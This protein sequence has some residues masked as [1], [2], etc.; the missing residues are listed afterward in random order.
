MAGKPC[1]CSFNLSHLSKE[2]GA[3]HVK[4]SASSYSRWSL[5]RVSLH[6][7]GREGVGRSIGGDHDR[8]HLAWAILCWN[9]AEQPSRRSTSARTC[10]KP[11]DAPLASVGLHAPESHKPSLSNLVKLLLRWSCG[12]WTSSCIHGHR[13][14]AKPA[15]QPAQL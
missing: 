4:T 1:V 10:R 14:R 12:G 9:S 6:N 15:V 8:L 7:I 11:R 5:G 13:D 2:C 3:I